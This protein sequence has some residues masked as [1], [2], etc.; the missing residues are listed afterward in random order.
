[1][2]SELLPL[3]GYRLEHHDGLLL[4]LF[5]YAHSLRRVNGSDKLI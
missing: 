4:L 5:L 2:M 3:T 1:M